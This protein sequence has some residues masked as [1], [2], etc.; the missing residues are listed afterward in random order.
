MANHTPRKGQIQKQ[1]N[2]NLRSQPTK[3]L[4]ISADTA[5]FHCT[6]EV[7]D[8]ETGRLELKNIRETDTTWMD[9]KKLHRIV[10]EMLAF[11]D[12][13]EDKQAIKLSVFFKRKGYYS[14]DVWEWQ[15]KWPWFKK[16]YKFVKEHI[17]DRREIG[18]LYRQLS[19]GMVLRSMP[20]YDDEWKADRKEVS[21]LRKEQQ[22]QA[23]DATFI[24]K[25]VDYSKEEK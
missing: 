25:K 24:I 15:Q 6:T 3:K 18:A 19:E 22:Q 12:D 8:N 23:G 5:T 4:K 17:G 11:A 20:M 21:D 13:T 2:H 14:S 16:A 1:T 9:E 7:L 10:D